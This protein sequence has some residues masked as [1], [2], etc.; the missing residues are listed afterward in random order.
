MP[1]KFCTLQGLLLI[2]SS[3]VLRSLNN[4]TPHRVDFQKRTIEC[5]AIFLGNILIFNGDIETE[6]RRTEVMHVIT[7]ND[8]YHLLNRLQMK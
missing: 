4:Q 2:K 8:H 6:T 3:V 5:I 7:L 1:Q